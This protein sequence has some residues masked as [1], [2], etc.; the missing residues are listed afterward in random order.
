MS[1]WVWQPS[2]G[3]SQT[4]PQDLFNGSREFSSER[5]V[6]ICWAMLSISSKVI[7]PLCLIF[8]P[9]LS[10]SW[11][12]FES[13][14]DQGG[15]RRYCLNLGLSWM[16]SFTVIL[17]PFQSPV[18]FALSSSTF[19][20]NKPRGLILG[21]QAEVLVF[22]TQLLRSDPSGLTV[23]NPVPPH[24]QQLLLFLHKT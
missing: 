24:I 13:F 10:V 6:H 21:V 2:H 11:L 9:L 7:F 12:L 1:S 19:F 14:E 17:I 16:V 15:G 20:G 4:G 8:S 3:S 5:L 23:L 18:A 22:Q